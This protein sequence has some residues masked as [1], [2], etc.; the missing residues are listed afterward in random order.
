MLQALL[1]EMH[2]TPFTLNILIYSGTVV[3]I[4]RGIHHLSYYTN[5]P[6]DVDTQKS[7]LSETIILS[8]HTIE[9]YGQIKISDHAKRTLS[10]ALYPCITEHEAIV[11]HYLGIEHDRVP[12]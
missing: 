3:Q 12:D 8:T 1:G 6:Y 4:R 11:A 5:T 10:R 7:C 9:L 2:E